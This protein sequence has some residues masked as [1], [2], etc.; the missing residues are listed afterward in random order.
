MA[1]IF[2]EVDEDVRR[3]KAAAFWEKHQ[4]LILGVAVAIVLATAGW[5]AWDYKRTR[6][7]EAA[8]AQYE[9]ALELDRQGKAAEAEKAFSDI[10]A[11]GPPGYALLARLRGAAEI[12]K[13]DR[14]EAVRLYDAIGEDAGVEPLLRDLA[15]LRAAF[16]R[17][18]EADAA[19]FARR[20]EPLAEAGRPFRSS[21][22]ELIGAKALQA[23][24]F[25][26]AAKYLDMIVVDSA[27]PPSL[28][29]RAELLLGLVRAGKP[30]SG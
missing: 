2:R 7:A 26:R 1:D 25:D 17:A 6:D 18:D 13:R 5:R 29:Q 21:A 19:E 4:T 24:D 30:T 23:G 8:G 27:A 9:A 3:E 10:A 22:R 28:R 15:R 20:L 11:K 12:A 16:L 14:P